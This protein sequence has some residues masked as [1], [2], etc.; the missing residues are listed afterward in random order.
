MSTQA[1]RHSQRGS[2]CV[3]RCLHGHEY[4]FYFPV[5]FV[6]VWNGPRALVSQ[7]FLPASISFRTK[8]SLLIIAYEHTIRKSANQIDFRQKGLFQLW[9]FTVHLFNSNSYVNYRID[10]NF[11]RPFLPL[12]LLRV[13]ILH[14]FQIFLC[15]S[16]FFLHR[17]SLLNFNHFWRTPSL[18]LSLFSK[19]QR[20]ETKNVSLKTEWGREAQ[21]NICMWNINHSKLYTATHTNSK[22]RNTFVQWIVYIFLFLRIMNTT[23]YCLDLALWWTMPYVVIRCPKQASACLLRTRTT[24]ECFERMSKI[25]CEGCCCLNVYIHGWPRL[26]QP[27]AFEDI[28]RRTAWKKYRNNTI[29]ECIF[30]GNSAKFKIKKKKHIKMAAHHSLIWKAMLFDTSFC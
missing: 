8:K 19:T 7:S 23:C 20:K 11:K 12:L 21:A 18:L 30:A 1:D 10:C 15:R 22:K 25:M 9:I 4:A 28:L 3:E 16:I 26:P 17:Y 13:S 24:W 2:L 6:I 29:V 5:S 27:H 14:N